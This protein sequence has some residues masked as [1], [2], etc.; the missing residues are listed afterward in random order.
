MRVSARVR[1]CRSERKEFQPAGNLEYRVVFPLSLVPPLVLALPP[2]Q[3]GR[4]DPQFDRYPPARVS[5]APARRWTSRARAPYC[6]RTGRA[7]CAGMMGPALRAAT[8]CPRRASGLPAV[9][10]S[11]ARHAECFGTPTTPRRANEWSRRGGE[12]ACCSR[13]RR[14]SR[15]N[16][17]AK[18]RSALSL[19]GRARR[20]LPSRSG[21]D[22]AD[23]VRR[24]SLRGWERLA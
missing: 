11:R 15:S 6:R 21:K 1:R 9:A 2:D 17:S 13:A 19:S 5:R 4:T 20:F 10:R 8:M 22:L 18:R 14:A 16:S 24:W 3:P 7:G 12:W 23:R